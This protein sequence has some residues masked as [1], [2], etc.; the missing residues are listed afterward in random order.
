MTRLPRVGVD[1][2][3]LS[4]VRVFPTVQNHVVY[5]GEGGVSRSLPSNEGKR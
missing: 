4:L 1:G 2:V 3:Y 5:F